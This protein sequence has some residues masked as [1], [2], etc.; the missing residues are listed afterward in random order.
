M[1]FIIDFLRNSNEDLE[2]AIRY[3]NENK[4]KL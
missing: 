4:A 2:K 3:L 1:D